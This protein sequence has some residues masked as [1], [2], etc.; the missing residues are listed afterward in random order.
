MEPLSA[1]QV[2]E[3]FGHSL[4]AFYGGRIGEVL[5]HPRYKLHIVTSRGQHILHREHPLGTP[6]GYA[7]AF[8]SNAVRRRALGGP[9]GR[10]GGR[11]A[12]RGRRSCGAGRRS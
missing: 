4:Q 9:P 12:R 1:E 7:G 10:R 2:S 5:S 3:A 11:A 8:L 6:L